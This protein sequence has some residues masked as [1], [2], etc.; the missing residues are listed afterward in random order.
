MFGNAS[1]PVAQRIE[2]ELAEL[3]AGGSSPSGCAKNRIIQ[4]CQYQ[5]K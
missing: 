1:A 4:L 5:N 2:H 3:G